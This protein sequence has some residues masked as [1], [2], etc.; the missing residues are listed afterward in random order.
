MES[1]RP[2]VMHPLAGRPMINNLLDTVSGLAP[3]RTIVVLAPGMEEVAETVA[4]AETVVQQ[5]QLG[6]ADAV[7]AARK[8]LAGFKG[9]VLVLYGDS[10]LLSGATINKV[11]EA[12]RGAAVVV[13]GFRPTGPNEYARIIADGGELERIVEFSDADDAQRGLQARRD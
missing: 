2:K 11:L 6:T 1:D 13:L 10:P 8:S 3:E 7:S 12:R 9:T 4:P 5:K